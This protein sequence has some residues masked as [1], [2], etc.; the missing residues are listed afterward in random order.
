MTASP[1]R[2]TQERIARDD[3]TFRAAN[4]RISAFAES[5]LDGVDRIPF[6]CECADR[7][8]TTVVLVSREEYRRIRLNPR[9]FVN[10]PGHEVALQGA[11]RVLERAER[12][13]IVEKTGYA[14]EVAEALAEDDSLLDPRPGTS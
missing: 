8:C 3:A 12:Y 6:I 9:W 13:V 1:D 11:G 7:T 2:Q 5:L 4:Q 10:A 14:G